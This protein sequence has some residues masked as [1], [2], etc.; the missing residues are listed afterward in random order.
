MIFGHVQTTY[1]IQE[2]KNTNVFFVYASKL[3]K[4]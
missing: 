3:F 1:K 4:M 2:N